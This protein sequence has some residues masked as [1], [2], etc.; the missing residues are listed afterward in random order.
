MDAFYQQVRQAIGTGENAP[1]LSIVTDKT[2][3]EQGTNSLS[4][5]TLASLCSVAVRLYVKLDG[6]DPADYYPA[7]RE[8]G[9]ENPEEDLV[10]ILDQAPTGDLPYSWAVLP[11]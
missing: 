8:A 11:E 5:Q 9:M 3:L 1:V 6:G 7:L 2:T 4:G 10:V